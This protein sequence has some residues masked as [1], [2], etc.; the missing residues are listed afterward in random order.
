MHLV[1]DFAW[2]KKWSDVQLDNN[3]WAMANDLAGG[4]ETWKEHSWD[5]DD[6]REGI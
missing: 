1:V 3:E 4:L 6:M 2:K 5:A